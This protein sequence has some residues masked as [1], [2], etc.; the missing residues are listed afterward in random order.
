MLHD[1]RHALRSLLKAPG[2]TAAAVLTLALGIGAN[3]AIYS[4]IHT[5]LFR[6]LPYPDPQRLVALYESMPGHGAEARGVVGLVALRAWRDQSKTLE[7]VAAYREKT[8]ILM[9]SD[10]GA[11]VRTLECT[12]GLPEILGVRPVLGRTFTRE[13]EIP[14]K[15]TVAMLSHDL[16]RRLGGRVDLVGSSVILDGRSFSVI[17]V[18]PEFF[19]FP[20]QY[21]AELFLPQMLGGSDLDPGNRSFGVIGRMRPGC[22]IKA[23]QADVDRM[24]GNLAIAYPDSH[25]GDRGLVVDFHSDQLGSGTP[26]MLLLLLGASGL[27]LLIA[28]INVSG[29]LLAKALA[30]ERETVLRMALGATTWDV[31]RMFLAEGLWIAVAG[32]VAGTCLA[33]AGSRSLLALLPGQEILRHFQSSRLEPMALLVA[34]A[35]GSLSALVLAVTPVF[36]SRRSKFEAILRQGGR[37]HSVAGGGFRR[38]L[39]AGAVAL[40]AL[41]LVGTGLMVHSLIRLKSVDL[42]FDPKGVYSFQVRRASSVTRTDE[43]VLAFQKDLLQNLR[44]RPGVDSAEGIDV[45]PFSGRGSA[46]GFLP[47]EQTPLP[48]FRWPHVQ[49]NMATPGYFAA[50]RMQIKAGRGIQDTDVQGYPWVMVVNETLARMMWPGVNAVGK[51]ARIGMSPGPV[52]RND[53]WEVVGVVKDIR[54]HEVGSPAE[55]EFYLPAA[56]FPVN[57]ITYVVRSS[58]QPAASMAPLVRNELRRMGLDLVVAHGRGLEYYLDHQFQ[59]RRSLLKLLALFS[60]LSLV[61]AGLGIYSFTA[62]QVEQGR[63]S[64]G[65]RIAL[66][67]T[68]IATF[69]AVVKSGLSLVAPGILAGLLLAGLSSRFLASM[70]YEIHPLDLPTLFAS[71]ACLVIAALLACLF[72]ALRASRTDPARALKEE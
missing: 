63:R 60:G 15:G 13:D 2:F 48:G 14:G 39:T 31:F 44:Q 36:Q 62:F 17:G 54:L 42:G 38:I 33:W 24:A 72:P 26:G 69:M 8:Q 19:N 18:L 4:A 59:G 37:G 11:Q 64:T 46:T 5:V 21:E 47:A 9:G 25:G 45:L 22:S 3:T 7:G 71:F 51:R 28:C 65:I 50:M 66:G 35:V 41:L 58:G 49:A 27:L 20:S 6:P 16:W 70:L 23:A 67:A 40:C 34:V 55:P 61:L 43:E 57:G 56:Q 53:P 10:G 68:P 30:R 12:A 29:L 1:L 32:S 52:P